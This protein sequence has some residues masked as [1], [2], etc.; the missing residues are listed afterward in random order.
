M[1]TSD[2]IHFSL[3]A[4]ESMRREVTLEAGALDAN[5]SQNPRD[6]GREATRAQCRIDRRY[7]AAARA[8]LSRKCVT[9]LIWGV[10]CQAGSVDFS[11]LR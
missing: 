8:A 4:D 3:K 10:V 5:A 11:H 1:S 2:R 9:N 7:F 6:T